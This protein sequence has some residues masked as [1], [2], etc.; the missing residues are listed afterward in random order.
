MDSWKRNRECTEID[1]W[2]PY[3]N[4]LNYFIETL[5]IYSIG[6]RIFS[7]GSILFTSSQNEWTELGWGEEQKQGFKY[8][9]CI[10]MLWV[11]SSTVEQHFCSLVKKRKK[12]ITVFP[13]DTWL[14]NWKVD[15]L[16]ISTISG[17]SFHE[18]F[19]KNFFLEYIYIS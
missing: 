5:S 19:K 4:E 13:T 15:C 3:S 8:T 17:N 9:S 12:H 7:G 10:Q 14:K 1:W 18:R 2:L 16:L 11:G 6:D